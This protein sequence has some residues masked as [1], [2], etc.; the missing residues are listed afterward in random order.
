MHSSPPL[1]SDGGRADG[2]KMERNG[3]VLAPLMV[4]GSCLLAIGTAAPLPGCGALRST[5]NHSACQAWDLC[6][7]LPIPGL[8]K[9][10]LHETYCISS[11]NT[12]PIILNISL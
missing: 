3:A 10:Y 12:A 11:K 5:K 2:E 9:Y 1:H 4:T 7:E 6:Q 8:N